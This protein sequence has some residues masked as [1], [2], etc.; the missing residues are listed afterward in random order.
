[1][2]NLQVLGTYAGPAD[3]LKLSPH[4]SLVLKVMAMGFIIVAD[5]V[6]GSNVA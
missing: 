6:V 5:L 1:M 3:H 4:N 2:V